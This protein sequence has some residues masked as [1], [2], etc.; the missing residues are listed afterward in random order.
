[1]T[2]LTQFFARLRRKPPEIKPPFFYDI[3][4]QVSLM[5][6]KPVDAKT[7]TDMVQRVEKEERGFRPAVRIIDL[8]T[9]EEI[10]G[11][12]LDEANMAVEVNPLVSVC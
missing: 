12:I 5:H 6:P 8:K 2:W 1:M 9:G 4:S 7:V 3:R 11:P 10:T